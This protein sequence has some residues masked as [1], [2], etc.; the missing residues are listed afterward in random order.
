ML[1]LERT[2]G[3]KI[4]FTI[5]ANR[6]PQTIELV[7]NR[8]QNTGDHDQRNSNNSRPTVRFAIHCEPQVIISHDVPL[9]SRKGPE[10]YSLANH[11]SILTEFGLSIRA[12][13]IL[14]KMGVTTVQDMTGVTRL[15]LEAQPNCEDPMRI[16]ITQSLSNFLEAVRR[17]L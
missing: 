8:I 11:I 13:N 3:S 1:V 14:E 10:G 15:Q 2:L 6:E 7:I 12:L 9:T 17:Q 16:E 4:V 5:P